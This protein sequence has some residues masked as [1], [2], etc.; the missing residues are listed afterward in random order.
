M[1]AALTALAKLQALARSG[2]LTGP[3]LEAVD[4]LVIAY[5]E[6][7]ILIVPKRPEFG[8]DGMA[9]SVAARL[10]DTPT[11]EIPADR[12]PAVLAARAAATAT[13]TGH[14]FAAQEF[15]NGVEILD[16]ALRTLANV[17]AD[18]LR[19][20]H[21]EGALPSIGGGFGVV[22]QAARDLPM[23]VW[24]L[25]GLADGALSHAHAVQRQQASAVA[26]FCGY[27]DRDAP[28]APPN[29]AEDDG[30]WSWACLACGNV[31]PGPDP[32]QVR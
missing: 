19:I 16:Q 32:A 20:L 31:T 24:R 14:G 29:R 5:E 28:H 13:L 21:G 12:L 3:A 11:T 26:L 6:E 1:S 15:R 17:S 25:K 30:S 27:C 10:I 23:T 8:E 4:Q 9:R 7:R 2:E 18:R 22:D